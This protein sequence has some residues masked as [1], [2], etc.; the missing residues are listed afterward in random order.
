MLS[1]FEIYVD[2]K[3]RFIKNSVRDKDIITKLLDQKRIKYYI[4]EIKLY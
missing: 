1:R 4:K 3:L 2:D